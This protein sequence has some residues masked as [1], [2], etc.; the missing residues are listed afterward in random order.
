L[1]RAMK[2]FVRLGLYCIFT[3]NTLLYDVLRQNFTLLNDFS[4]FCR[5]S[6]F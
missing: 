5:I 2:D 4:E 3:N 1:E 6:Y